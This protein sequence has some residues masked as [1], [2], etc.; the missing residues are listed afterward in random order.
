MV[1]STRILGSKKIKGKH[2]RGKHKW[3]TDTHWDK[4]GSKHVEIG[5]AQIL[6]S[7]N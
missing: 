2:E 4:Q 3:H 6:A 7:I 5:I 1:I